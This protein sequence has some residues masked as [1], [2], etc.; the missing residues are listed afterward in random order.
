MANY[1]ED[2]LI[3]AAKEADMKKVLTRFA[4]NLSAD[5]EIGELVDLDSI[6]KVEDI[7]E[8]Y[9]QV[10]CDVENW[11]GSAFSGAPV[12]EEVAEKFKP[13]PDGEWGE[14][15]PMSEEASTALKRYGENWVLAVWYSTAWRPNYHDLDLFF[16]GLPAG[17][18]GV[19]LLDADEDDQCKSVSAFSGLFHGCA[20]MLVEC[21]EL[22][23]D[24]WWGDECIY[25]EAMLQLRREWADVSKPDIANLAELAQVAAVYHWGSFEWCE[26]DDEGEFVEFEPPAM[27]D[28]ADERISF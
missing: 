2:L 18:Y 23:D 7:R 17:D 27:N 22:C 26:Y 21:G 14:G 13:R 8:L 16:M 11:Y 3:I 9:R 12:L 25:G 4:M 19:A 20:P 1:H 24:D 10:G 28:D 6:A 5:D 15:R